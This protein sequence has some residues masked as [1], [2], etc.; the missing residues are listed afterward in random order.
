MDIKTLFDEA[1]LAQA[2]YAL[3]SKGDLKGNE[4]V[5][6]LLN[7]EDNNITQAQ[8][9][10]FASKYIVVQQ[11]EM[12]EPD[13]GFSATL[14]KNIET[15]EYHLANRGSDGIFDVDFTGANAQNFSWGMSYDQVADLINFYHRLTTASTETAPQFTFEEQSLEPGTIPPSGSVFRYHEFEDDTQ[16]PTA[17]VYLVFKQKEIGAVGLGNISNTEDLNVSGHSLGGHLASTF[18]LLFPSVINQTSTFNS[19]GIVGDQFD[20]LASAIAEVLD[21]VPDKVAEPNVNVIDIKS[22][23]DPVSSLG[24]LHLGGGLV[25]VFIEVE[26]TLT[27]LESHDMDRLV[28]SLAVMN[29]LYTLDNSFTLA[30]ANKLLPLASSD[31]FTELEGVMNY[32]ARLFGQG[33]VAVTNSDHDEVYSTIKKIT[34][35]LGDKTYQISEIT[36]AI[37]DQAATGDKAALY[38]LINLQPF[39]VR[40]TTQGTTDAL[41]QS[42]SDNGMLDIENY[43]DEYLADRADMLQ[44]LIQYNEENLEYGKKLGAD[45]EGNF[46]Y[47]DMSSGVNNAQDLVLK[48]DGTGTETYAQIKF[49]TE[50]NDSGDKSIVGGG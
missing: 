28:D 26:D 20:E 38:A 7:D 8:A 3:F 25:D 40:G 35:S 48:I 32:L 31:E 41:Y 21:I 15:Q 34:D 37:A 10:Y 27:D 13:T 43:T 12:P 46:E 11:S 47:T 29:L 50:G 5:A 33:E 14:F 16:E 18:S 44:W 23:L 45:I 42:H 1:L 39:V 4:L 9:E 30:K 49:G 2:A 6:A 22:P 17:D 36:S 19:A 24:G